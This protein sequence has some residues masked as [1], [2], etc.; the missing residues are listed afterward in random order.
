VKTLSGIN[1]PGWNRG[2]TGVP[3]EGAERVLK[4]WQQAGA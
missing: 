4:A 2:V 1:F 3:R